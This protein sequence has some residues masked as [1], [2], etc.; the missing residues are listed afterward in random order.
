MELPAVCP[1][2]C[3]QSI[4]RIGEVKLYAEHLPHQTTLIAGSVFRCSHWHVFAMFPSE[5]L[6]HNTVC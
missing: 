1:Y 6:S 3:D 2:C 4:E 5:V